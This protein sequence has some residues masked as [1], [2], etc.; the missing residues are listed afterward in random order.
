MC[1]YASDKCNDFRASVWDL[2]NHKLKIMETTEKQKGTF[3]I[4]G[5][6][7]LQSK[8]LKEKY[9][10]LTDE[11]VKFESGKE[12]E[13]IKRLETRLNKKRDEVIH[14]L[15]RGRVEKV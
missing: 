11:D 3:T 2:Y 15:K 7:D 5:N 4:T 14:I 8:Q 6:W 12:H 9:T 10:S 13:L 1:K